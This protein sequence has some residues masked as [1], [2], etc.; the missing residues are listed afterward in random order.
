MIN[1]LLTKKK[2]FNLSSEKNLIIKDD[3]SVT[4][5]N[6]KICISEESNTN[7]QE[8]DKANLMFSRE[9]FCP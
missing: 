1:T 2:A 6:L 9:K 7:K 4:E 3:L 8:F 5:T